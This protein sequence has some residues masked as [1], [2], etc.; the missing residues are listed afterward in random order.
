MSHSL[1]FPGPGE[2]S[3][4]VRAALLGALNH[5]LT[6]A[7]TWVSENLN[8]LSPDVLNFLFPALIPL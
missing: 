3:A 7:L 1:V 2:P 4:G 8:E 5:E 6:P